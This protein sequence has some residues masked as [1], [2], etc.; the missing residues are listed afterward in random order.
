MVGL[1]GTDA[2]AADNAGR[3]ARRPAADKRLPPDTRS[4]C[5]KSGGLMRYHHLGIP[6]RFV[7]EGEIY[8]EDFKVFVSGFDQ[9]PYGVE[10]LR[11]ET[12]CPLPEIV[13]TIPH[14]AFAVRDL[15]AAIAG[16]EILIKPNRPSEGVT[17][18]FILDNGAPVEFLQFDDPESEIWPG[19]GSRMENERGVLEAFEA[20]RHGMLQKDPGPLEAYIASDYEG[21]GADGAKNNRSM[22]LAAY[23][24][25]GVSLETFDVS[26]LRARVMGS[27]ALVTGL[28]RMAGS[29][30]EGRFEHC[31]RFLDVFEH[32]GP[33]WQLVAS[34]TTDIR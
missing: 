22:M 18:A 31:A 11:Y 17:V 15:E 25:G 3:V 12:G 8:L 20:I 6:T 9:S 30:L 19:S 24:A 33:S 7:R 2:P 16:K 1:I 27:T 10:W 26:D 21:C 14:V 29:H 4:G 32:R 13:K 34:Q 5:R 28:A 23:R